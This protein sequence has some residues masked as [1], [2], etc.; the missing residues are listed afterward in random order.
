MKNG[1]N[2]E[3]TL[4]DETTAGFLYRRILKGKWQLLTGTFQVLIGELHLNI[5][6]VQ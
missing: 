2:D 6:G 3:I 1:T 5:C 4:L